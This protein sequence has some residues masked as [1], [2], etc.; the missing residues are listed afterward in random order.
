MSI[1][2]S[3]AGLAARPMLSVAAPYLIGAA[4]L[5][6]T[7]GIAY[8]VHHQR[9]IGRDEIRA[10]W[11][12]EK[13]KQVLALAAA[14]DAARAREQALQTKATEAINAAS[15]RAKKS[16]VAAAAVRS[17]NDSLRDDLN[18]ARS[19]LSR[20]SDAAVRKY[21]ATAGAVFGECTAE[22][23]RLAGAAQGH[24]TDSLM[25]QQAWPKDK[26]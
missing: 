4:V 24:A 10:E 22:V 11:N 16:Q 21:A 17:V 7:G 19:D 13:A 15:E 6:A 9:E 8:E 23:E 12:G 20:A 5:A 14:N 1:F 25:F 3:L 2:T 18:A 26:P